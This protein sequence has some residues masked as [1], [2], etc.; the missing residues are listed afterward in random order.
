MIVWRLVLNVVAT[1]ETDSPLVSRSRTFASSAGVRLGGLPRCLPSAFARA[2]P[3]CVRSISRSRSNSATAAITCIV[4][5]PAEL[6][7]STPPSAR[8]WTRTPRL[9]SDSTVV[10]TSIAFRPKR[11]S[12]VTIRTSPDSN[13]LVNEAKPGRSMACTDPLMRSVTMRFSSIWYPAVLISRS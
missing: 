6:V 4:I 13:L 3:D 1:E 12:L 7:K 10:R 8:Q 9:A 2:R 5:F 11:S